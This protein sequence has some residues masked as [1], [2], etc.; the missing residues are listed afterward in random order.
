VL[1]TRPQNHVH[2]RK[3]LLSVATMLLF[4]GVFGIVQG[5]AAGAQSAGAKT[6]KPQAVKARAAKG[7]P[8][9]RAAAAKKPAPAQPPQ[10][11]SS[12]CIIAD[13]GLVLSEHS[14]DT[15]RPAASLVKMMLMLA[16]GEGLAD[17]RWTLD[18]PV[19]V[20]PHA[21]H[22]GGTQVYLEAGESWTLEQLMPAVA[23]A[24]ANDAAMAV[25]EALWG[26]E[27]AY[28]AYINERAQALGMT[29]SRFS[30]VHGLPPDKGECSDATTARDLAALAQQLLRY[31][32]IM[33]WVGRQELL[34]RT[35]EAIKYNTNK[36][37][38]QFDGCDGI[39]TGYTREAG[40]C[41]VAS[42][43]RDGIRLIVA[44]M[45]YSDGKGRFALAKELLEDG[46]RQ[47]R[48]VDCLAEGQALE[49]SVPVENGQT[50]RVYLRAAQPLSVVVRE[51]DVPELQVR[52]NQPERL[53]APLAAGTQ[54][55]D[56]Q[57]C[58]HDRPLASAPL[59]LAE[60]V[61]AATLSFKIKRMFRGRSSG[62]DNNGKNG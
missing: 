14:A 59:V 6:P 19:V 1:R 36:L 37:L 57:V 28:L 9:T 12:L 27:E 30:S 4:S 49:T 45:G 3:A 40:H 21:Q 48:R 31:P 56:V 50:E 13:S 25:A 8:K 61:P 33:E 20:T 10:D 32:Q 54:L 55:G 2:L 22:M 51:A 34:F 62:T 5:A 35:G 58:L 52:V 43:Q 16:V 18:T 24:S 46:F 42:A 47:V 29:H 39:K 11:Y 53:E 23:V 41:V 15:P 26:S 17:G 44:V 38:W 7:T 60:D